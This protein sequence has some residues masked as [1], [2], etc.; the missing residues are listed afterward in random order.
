MER[1]DRLNY[2]NV[3]YEYMSEEDEQEKTE[4]SSEETK[5]RLAAAE[6]DIH[7]IVNHSMA[8]YHPN[9]NET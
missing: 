6:F 2:H 4:L 8:G 3:Q 5:N 1:G 9:L 7:R